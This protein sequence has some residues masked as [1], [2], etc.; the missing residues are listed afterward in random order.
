MT[1]YNS[2]LLR[3]QLV[4]KGVAAYLFGS[5]NMLRGE[6]KGYVT[7]DAIAANVATVTVS[8]NQG[9]IPSVGDLITIWA[10]SNSSGAFNVVRAVITGVSITA[11]TGQGTIT[12]ALTASNQA[13]TADA[14][15]F[16]IEVAE[17]GETL[18]NNTFS[19]ACMIQAPQGDSQFTITTAI[20]FP[21][22]PTAATVSLQAAVRDVAAEYTTIGTAAVLAA[23]AFTAGPVASFAL[24]RAN[25]Y[26]F[27]IT[28]VSGGTSPTII[29]KVLS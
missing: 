21:S 26:R 19:T 29:A 13:A 25:F 20:S 4:Q 22:S 7:Q 28:G 9:P 8:I 15:A 16:L 12:F 10:T 27:A 5:L 24:Q 1:V 6:T 18:T 23:S 14:G 2:P 11:T 17:V 3:P